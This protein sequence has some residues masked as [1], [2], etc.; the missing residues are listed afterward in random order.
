M[1]NE[2]EFVVLFVGGHEVLVT[3]NPSEL[4]TLIS[5]RFLYG[6]SE[7]DMVYRSATDEEAEC[8][9]I[10]PLSHSDSWWEGRACIQCGQP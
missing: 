5:E 6:D 7:I 4:D 10:A 1:L 8:S 3:C 9:A 2:V